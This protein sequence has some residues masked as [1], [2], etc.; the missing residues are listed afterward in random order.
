MQVGVYISFLYVII[1][2]FKTIVV[3]IV[4]TLWFINYSKR[5]SFVISGYIKV[6]DCKSLFEYKNKILKIKYEAE[7]WINDVTNLLRCKKFP[8]YNDIYF[9]KK[10]DYFLKEGFSEYYPDL[11][12]DFKDNCFDIKAINFE[13]D[14]LDFFYNENLFD[15]KLDYF[16]KS[17]VISLNAKSFNE[18]DSNRYNIIVDAKKM[19]MQIIV[20]KGLDSSF[21]TPITLNKK[22]RIEFDFDQD[23]QLIYETITE[24]KKFISF[25]S[26]RKNIIF[27]S[28]TIETK[29]EKNLLHQI[30]TIEYID[31][32]FI[33]RESD[34]KYIRDHSYFYVNIYDHIDTLFNKISS[35]EMCLLNIPKD[36]YVVNI[37]NEERIL[38]I[39]STFENL[40]EL[41]YNGKIT[42]KEVSIKMREYFFDFLT[43]KEN[44]IKFKSKRYVEFWEKIKKYVEFDN[45]SSKINEVLKKDNYINSLIKFFY[46]KKNEDYTR[47]LITERI[48]KIRNKCAH[49]EYR[50]FA[51]KGDLNCI[52]ALEL[53]VYYLQLKLVGVDICNINV[54]M[55]R[56]FRISLASDV[57]LKIINK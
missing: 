16:L 52:K 57:L 51:E 23:Y 28:I 14:E 9:Y 41:M 4:N 20:G 35:N 29:D 45:F 10:S 27:R 38:M 25:I 22:I 56:I 21:P 31:K 40:F 1:S 36:D 32:S 50:K 24:V 54:I 3:S 39:T 6:V 8:Y 13:L 49:G 12:I 30:G 47:S 34:I 11:V 53:I 43:S 55:Y 2:L 5:S 15:A 17:G 33:E 26:Y 48:E 19:I 18:T 37:Y 44:E 7:D 46:D 42:H